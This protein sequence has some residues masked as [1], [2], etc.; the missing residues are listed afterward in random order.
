ML[1]KYHICMFHVTFGVYN[2][3]QALV[4]LSSIIESSFDLQIIIKIWRSFL[5]VN[6]VV[7]SICYLLV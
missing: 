3:L 5:I 4:G 1:M 6:V 2:S 7:Y